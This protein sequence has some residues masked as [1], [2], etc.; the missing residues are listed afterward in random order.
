MKSFIVACVIIAQVYGE[1]DSHGIRGIGGQLRR[2]VSHDRPAFR[3]LEYDDHLDTS[4]GHHGRRTYG[5]RVPVAT[6]IGHPGRRTYGHRL[7]VDTSVGHHGRRTYGH[8]PVATSVGHYGRRTY[9]HRRP[10]AKYDGLVDLGEYMDDTRVVEVPTSSDNLL[11]EQYYGPGEQS[12]GDMGTFASSGLYTQF[13]GEPTRIL[14]RRLQPVSR[15]R[16]AAPR[17]VV[18]TDEAELGYEY[19]YDHG[20]DG[21]HDTRYE[22][23]RR[24]I[25]H[26]SH[27]GVRRG[28]S[29]HVVLTDE[30]ELGYDG[31]SRHGYEHGYDHVVPVSRYVDHTSGYSRHGYVGHS[32]GQYTM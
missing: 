30:A 1:Y 26:G 15:A 28:V 7:P 20:Y 32:D 31:H 29:G 13:V 22:A 9:G 3:H 11:V 10:V 18:L 23:V 12:L 16:L 19:G 2:V 24:P 21:H 8:L 27:G 6:T 17:R 5:H 14:F 4:V 25:S